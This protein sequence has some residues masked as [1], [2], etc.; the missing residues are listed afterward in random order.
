MSNDIGSVKGVS[1][2]GQ[3]LN[4]ASG[5]PCQG[6]SPQQGSFGNGKPRPEHGASS[7]QP[8][9]AHYRGLTRVKTGNN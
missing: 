5:G 2:T 7:Q 6:Y 3:A 8:T 1:L 9:F 4:R